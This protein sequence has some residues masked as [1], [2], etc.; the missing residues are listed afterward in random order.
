MEMENHNSLQE[1]NKDN[2]LY[3][4]SSGILYVYDDKMGC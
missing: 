1:I 2:K 3:Y 4:W